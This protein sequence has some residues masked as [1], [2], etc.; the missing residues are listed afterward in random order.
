MT[1]CLPLILKKS[2][3]AST[4]PSKLFK[5]FNLKYGNMVVIIKYTLQDIG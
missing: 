5:K 4:N 1:I 2:F 3:Q